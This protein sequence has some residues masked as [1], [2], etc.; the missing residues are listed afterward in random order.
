MN[1]LFTHKN[2]IYKVIIRERKSTFG[3]KYHDIDCQYGISKIKHK[4]RLILGKMIKEGYLCE[5]IVL[6]I[7][8]FS[9]HKYRYGG[10]GGE[11]VTRNFLS[12]NFVKIIMMDEHKIPLEKAK[13]LFFNTLTN[14]SRV[15]EEK[16]HDVFKCITYSCYPRL[17]KDS[18]GT[19]NFT[20]IN[21]WGALK[22]KVLNTI[23]I[24]YN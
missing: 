2:S 1:T 8:S 12:D 14:G 21:N 5:D 23:V 6:Y 7:L 11:F 16:A 13:S 9:C 3:Y 18:L 24:F 17:C 4:K 15:I 22:L 19:I 10:R 20:K